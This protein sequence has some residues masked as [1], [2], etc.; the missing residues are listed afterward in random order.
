MVIY[1]DKEILMLDY[2]YSYLQ[3]MKNMLKLCNV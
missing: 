1:V 2:A 3:N